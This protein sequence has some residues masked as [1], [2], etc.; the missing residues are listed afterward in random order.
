MVLLCTSRERMYKHR[1]IEC[2]VNDSSDYDYIYDSAVQNTLD[3][4]FKWADAQDGTVSFEKS[5]GDPSYN[6]CLQ[7][8]AKFDDKDTYALFK[9]VYGNKPFNKLDTHTLE[10]THE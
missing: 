5:W 8:D 4:Y 1:I 2:I 7:V 10:F 3:E 6:L 9:L